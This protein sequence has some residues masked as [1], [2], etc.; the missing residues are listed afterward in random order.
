M[1]DLLG[2]LR[3]ALE[4][5]KS[6][7]VERLKV[8]E[9]VIVPLLLELCREEYVSFHHSTPGE[10]SF[11]KLLGAAGSSSAS[12]SQGPKEKAKGSKGAKNK[13]GG[14]VNKGGRKSRNNSEN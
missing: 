12:T 5:E 6:S 13:G 4:H 3:D 1:E 11:K 2:D 8:K 9:D 10:G 7:L 14:R